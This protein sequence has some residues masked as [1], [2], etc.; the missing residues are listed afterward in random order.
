MT[1]TSITLTA[2]HTIIGNL[3]LPPVQHAAVRLSSAAPEQFTATFLMLPG[4]AIWWTLVPTG[5]PAMWW[6]LGWIGML[7]LFALSFY[8]VVIRAGQHTV[9]I[10][11]RG[12]PIASQL[13][14]WWQCAQAMASGRCA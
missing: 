13:W 14:A 3:T 4:L 9:E 10:D 6:A 12:V 7:T 2:E 5:H 8:S 11:C 1:K